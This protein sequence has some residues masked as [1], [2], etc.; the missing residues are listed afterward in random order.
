MRAGVG[1]DGDTT[2]R[3]LFLYHTCPFS[4]RLRTRIGVKR[5]S[6]LIAA[7]HT[8]RAGGVVS[9]AQDLISK[10]VCQTLEFRNLVATVG[11][12]QERKQS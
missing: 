1:V 4:Y 10:Q 11:C 7:A 9:T 6:A 8:H 12:L 2:V 3:F 5:G